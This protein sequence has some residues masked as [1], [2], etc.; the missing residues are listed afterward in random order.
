M[1][2]VVFEEE[3][4]GY[5]VDADDFEHIYDCVVVDSAEDMEVCAAC[6]ECGEGDVAKVTWID[7]VAG[8][9]FGG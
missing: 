7:C 8:L 3:C 5:F 9:F 6:D 2:F 1:A 4:F